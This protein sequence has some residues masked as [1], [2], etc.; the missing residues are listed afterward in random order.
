MK[1]D[2]LRYLQ[3][4]NISLSAAGRAA[5]I[6]QQNVRKSLEGNPK[7]STLLAV[8]NGLG[9][10]IRDFFYPDNEG[11]EETA[12]AP[13]DGLFAQQAD[14]QQD[15]AQTASS[16]E[17]KADAEG[18]QAQDAREMMYCPHCGTKFFVVNVPTTN[19]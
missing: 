1:L 9:L 18:A 16:S 5:G 10:D 2:A 7:A 12:T 3:E 6:M 11:N 8:A 19:G 4:R 15:A 13:A 17:A 14:E